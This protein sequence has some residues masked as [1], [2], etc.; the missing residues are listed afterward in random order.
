MTDVGVHAGPAVAAADA[1]LAAKIQNAHEHIPQNKKVLG[2]FHAAPLPIGG[3][4]HDVLSNHISSQTRKIYSSNK[5]F[6]SVVAACCTGFMQWNDVA[7][8]TELAPER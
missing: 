3:E 5:Y 8:A 6:T 7:L 4:V 2:S 1:K